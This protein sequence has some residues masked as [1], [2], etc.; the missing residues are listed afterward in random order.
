MKKTIPDKHEYISELFKRHGREIQEKFLDCSVAICG[1]GGLGSNIA[2]LL[3]RAGVGHLHIIDFDVVELSNIHR[4]QYSISQIGLHKTRATKENIQ[5]IFPY[6]EVT[7][8][9]V[10]ITQNNIKNLLCNDSIICEALDKAEQKAMLVN[11]VAENFND[12]YLICG[13]GMAGMDSANSI[14]TKK[15][16]ERFYICGDGKSDIKDGLGLISSRAAVC[17]GHMANKVLQ[18]IAEKF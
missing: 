2:L 17:G 5:N 7:A 1:L 3:A 16:T 6:C 9:T 14:Q 11:A 8:D 13:S 10:R 4:Q 18:I 15:I 12:K